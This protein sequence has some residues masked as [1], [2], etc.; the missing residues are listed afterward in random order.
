MDNRMSSLDIFFI[1]KQPEGSR[2]FLQSLI[3]IDF[4]RYKGLLKV[5]LGTILL[6]KIFKITNRS[7]F[8]IDY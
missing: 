4:E 2:Y 1:S 8:K 7:V 3:N 6:Y 5:Y